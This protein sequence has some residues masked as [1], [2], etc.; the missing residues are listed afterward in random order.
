MPARLTLHPPHRASR[1][2]LIREGE[3]LVVGRD[4]ECGLVLEDA[5]VSKRH[6]R[7]D[8]DGEGWCLEDLGSKNG[9]SL[10]GVPA[11]GRRRLSSG[12]WI[13]FGGLVARFDTITTQEAEALDAHRLARLQ[14]SLA[15]RRRL[16]ARLDPVDLLLRFLH[17]TMEVVGADRG[18]ILVI[19]PD[20]ATRVELAAGYSPEGLA[21]EDS[22]FTGSMGAVQRAL[23]TGHS[24]VVSDAQKDGF[25]GK[26]PSVVKLGLGAVA[27]VPIRYE[28]RIV[29]LLYVDSRTP[30]AAFDELDLEIL[31]A[32]T[33][34]TAVAIASIDLDRRLRTLVR[35]SDPAVAERPVLQELQRRIRASLR[36][37]S[38]P[39]K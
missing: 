9:T 36:F 31:E 33:E 32:L 11:D 6:A 29:G 4:P 1:F 18:F 30:R 39:G 27:C 23:E 37:E 3:S 38:P 7:V 12:T 28:G 17:S 19:A 16:G 21:A 10:D 5:A 2:L 34:Q 35:P 26:R 22:R 25:L 8:W 24:V 14:T 20:G 13:S 15:M